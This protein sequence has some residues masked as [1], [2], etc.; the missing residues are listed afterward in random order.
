MPLNDFIEIKESATLSQSY[1]NKNI[2]IA[3]LVVDAQ[4]RVTKTGRNFGILAIEDY[5]G[6]TEIALWSD[7]YVKFTNYL[8]KGKNILLQGFFKTGWKKEG[9]P[10]RYEFKVLSI[11]LLESAKQ[12][13]TKQVDLNLHVGAVS[14]ELVNFME[15]NIKNNPGKAGLKINLIEPTENL[16]ITLVSKDKGFTMNDEMA[17]FLLNNPDIEVNVAMNTN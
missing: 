3:G 12:N 5:S 16:N 17:N 8:E 10:D 7:D 6:K 13:L 9:E 1:V 14:P 2:R 11:N 4:H 15:K